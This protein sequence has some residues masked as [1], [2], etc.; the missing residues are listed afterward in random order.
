VIADSLRH[1]ERYK[2]LHPLL[3][4]GLLA[5]QR[6]A[7][8]PPADGRHELRGPQLYASIS[9]YLTTDPSAKPFEAHRRYID[10]QCVLAGRETLY[11]AE[12][13][14]LQV[15]QEY[16]EGKD[17]AHYADPGGAGIPLPLEPGRFAVL[18]PEDAHKPGCHAMKEGAAEVRKLVI[19]VAL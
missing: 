15:Q 16:S 4:E 7:A 13:E 6:L 5:L 19:K 1:L 17:T 11:W 18:F 9:R 3:A 12:V 14:R 2:G 8:A 10:I